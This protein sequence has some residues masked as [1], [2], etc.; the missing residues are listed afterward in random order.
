MNSSTIPPSSSWKFTR[1]S[2]PLIWLITG[3]SSGLGLC[4]ARQAQASGHTV[5]ATSRDP[6]RTPELVQEITSHPTHPGLWLRLDVDDDSAPAR[7][8]AELQAHQG[9]GLAVDVLVNNAG[10]SIHQAVESFTD[11]E[12][13]RQFETVFFGPYRLIR[14]VLPGMRERRFGV[15]VNVSSGA[16][17]EGRESMGAYAAA[18]AAMD[19]ECGVQAV[20]F[21]FCDVS[22]LI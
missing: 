1:P 2:R 9:G 22:V 8:L 17:L 14:A 21:G 13:R 10:W 19:G 7:V 16:G 11:E 18:K 15:V 3:C 5:I 12:V 20:V 4:I 6:S